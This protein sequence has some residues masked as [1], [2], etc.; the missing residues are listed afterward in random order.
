MEYVDGCRIEDGGALGNVKFALRTFRNACAANA[1]V[2]GQ[3]TTDEQLTHAVEKLSPFGIR[4]ITHLFRWAA[5]H[6]S[7]KQRKR[8]YER[9]YEW[10]FKRISDHGSKVD[11]TMYDITK[12]PETESG[13]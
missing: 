7:N 1:N 11:R 4:V 5:D 12:Q 6:E 9:I 10:I 13:I 3:L 8:E 2:T